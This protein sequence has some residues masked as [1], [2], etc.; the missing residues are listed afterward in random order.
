MHA[1]ILKCLNLITKGFICK[2]MSDCELNM[3]IDR[4]YIDIKRECLT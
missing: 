3:R 2:S 4:G 1:N